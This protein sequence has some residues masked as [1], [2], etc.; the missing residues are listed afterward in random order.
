MSFK[1]PAVF[2]T[3]VENH[4]SF[5]PSRPPRPSDVHASGSVLDGGCDHIIHESQ[6]FQ[7][8]VRWLCCTSRTSISCTS[9]YQS[10][11]EVPPK[12]CV[13]GV[14][15]GAQF[16]INGGRSIRKNNPFVRPVFNSSCCRLCSVSKRL[17]RRSHRRHRR[18][19]EAHRMKPG[20]T[21]K[22][23]RRRYCYIFAQ[24]QVYVLEIRQSF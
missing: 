15:L 3:R 12:R 24:K 5:L 4:P 19:H 20:K 17:P 10:V 18:S 13:V 14:R 11:C 22:D 2:P 9:K 21:K 1:V 6:Y 23:L 8:V 7:A 16:R